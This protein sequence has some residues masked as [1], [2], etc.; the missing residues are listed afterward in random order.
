MVSWAALKLFIKKSWTWLKHNWWLPVGG[1]LLAVGFLTGRRNNAG[2]LKI[3]QSRKEMADEEIRS[4]QDAHDKKMEV[5]RQYAEGL[6]R[7]AEEKGIRDAEVT[8]ENRE[9]LLAAAEKAADDPDAMAKEL[10]KL[11]GL[12]YVE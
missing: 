9:A 5:Q 6:K 10:A 11:Y 1:V 7:L 3:M 8:K 2:I 4:L 12:T